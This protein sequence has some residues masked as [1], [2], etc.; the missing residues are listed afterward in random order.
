MKI[1][2]KF[3][4]IELDEHA[5]IKLGDLHINVEPNEGGID[6]FKLYTATQVKLD[7]IAKM[8]PHGYKFFK[9]KSIVGQISNLVD[10]IN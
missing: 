1:Y 5:E 6:E 7:Y 8:Q 10:K 4:I 3:T 9:V 2:S